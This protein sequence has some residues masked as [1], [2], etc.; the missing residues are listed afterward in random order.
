GE[1]PDELNERRDRAYF[2]MT[3]AENADWLRRIGEPLEFAGRRVLDIGCG[4]GALSLN[5]AE[6]GARSVT[7]I[8][9]DRD[10]IRFARAMLKERYARYADRVRF[11]SSDVAE[12]RGEFDL[13]ISKDTFEHV[14]DID[15]LLA[16]VWRLLAPGGRLAVG[17]SPLYY[18]PKG[19]H[20]RWRLGVPWL[21]AVLPERYLAARISRLTG[22]RVER[23]TD[24]GL[25]RLTPAQFRSEMARY[26]WEALAIRYNR[27][28]KWPLRVA[29]LLRRTRVL[30]KYATVSIYAVARKGRPVR[31]ATGA[32]PV[33]ERP[34]A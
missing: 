27:G 17:F 31:H 2:E 4:H 11:L 25:N 8:D 33:L 13:V 30:E 20:G 32:E 26:P 1:T 22:A 28:E 10:R 21:H 5:A 16:N 15:R 34:A 23:A 19:D 14:E 12:L 9:L 7:G 24:I 6:W 18:S 3:L 29:E